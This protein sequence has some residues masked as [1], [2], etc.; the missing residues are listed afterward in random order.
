MIRKRR[1]AIKVVVS[2]FSEL[3]EFAI[4]LL[5]VIIVGIQRVVGV[6]LSLL[7]FNLGLEPSEVPI[8]RTA[9][10]KT[11]VKLQKSFYVSVV[12]ITGTYINQRCAIFNHN[13][14]LS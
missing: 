7:M 1:K 5:L 8:I 12:I 9:Q 6:H 4:L 3:D 11:L 13:P 10:R 14:V 2:L